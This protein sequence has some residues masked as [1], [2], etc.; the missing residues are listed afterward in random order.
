[1]RAARAL[2]ELAASGHPWALPW[3]AA[4]EFVALVSHP[5]AVAR[6]LDPGEAWAF[7]EAL[8]ASPSANPLPPTERH[9]RVAAEVL[10]LAGSDAVRTPGFATAVLLREHGVGEL[11]SA[12]RDM[13]RFPFLVVRDPLHGPVWSAGERPTRRYRRL[14]T[15]HPPGLESR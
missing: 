5:H 14:A 12:R 2:E 6:A 1:V 13:R 11:L 15:P 9:A 7:V 4:E 10:E 8:L 3:S